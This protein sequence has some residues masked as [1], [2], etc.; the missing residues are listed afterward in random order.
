MVIRL[1]KCAL[2][3]WEEGH[4]YH[5]CPFFATTAGVKNYSFVNP[6][7]FITISINS[8][9]FDSSLTNENERGAFCEREGDLDGFFRV[10]NVFSLA[11]S[12]S[13]KFVNNIKRQR[14]RV[15]HVACFNRSL[16]SPTLL[17]AQSREIQSY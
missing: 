3:V 8:P 9:S 5:F 4:F 7:S 14:R 16:L 10:S 15:S 12:P 13:F 1:I 11:F 2:R 6:N 17:F